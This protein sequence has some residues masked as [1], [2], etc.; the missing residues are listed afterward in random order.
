ML[1][2]IAGVAFAGAWKTT[3]QWSQVVFAAIMVLCV[4]P[5]ILRAYR[6]EPGA[7]EE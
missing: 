5:S 4:L 6:K 3:D 7:D 2:L 1:A